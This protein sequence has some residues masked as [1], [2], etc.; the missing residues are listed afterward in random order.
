VFRNKEL[1]RLSLLFLIL[2]VAATITGFALNIAAGVVAICSAAAFGTAFLIFTRSRYRELA[3]IADQVDAVMHHEEYLHLEGFEEGELAILKSEINK[4]AIC[5]REQ[6]ASLKEDK[7]YLADS[8][9]DIAHQLRTPLTSA[10]LIVSLLRQD[11]GTDSSKELVHELEELLLQMDWLIT[12]LLKISRLD[13]GVV[14]FQI[15]PV[16]VRKLIA[17]SLRALAIQ[18]ELM[19]IEI[20]VNVP[21]DCVIPG[22]F[23]WLVEAVRNIL[24]N[25]VE[26]SGHGGRIEISCK[27]NPLFLR[28]IIHDSGP[29]FDLDELPYIFVRFFSGNK[30]AAEA[31]ER[32]NSCP[33]TKDNPNESSG[34]GLEAQDANERTCGWGIGLALSKMIVNRLNGSLTA[35]NHPIK[36]AVFSIRFEK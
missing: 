36:G 16:P 15:K 34:S 18:I 25:C 11:G 28:L 3:E 9:A 5:I 10:N 7:R 8:L 20:Q 30:M 31:A 22:D 35:A 26:S 4:M 2:A 12:T 23:H 1:R 6:N 13:A 29:G 14:D 19:D 27:D 33:S 21:D 17:A 24:K 32:D